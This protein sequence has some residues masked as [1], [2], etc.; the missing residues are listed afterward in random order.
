LPYRFIGHIAKDLERTSEAVTAYE[1]ALERELAAAD[2]HDVRA[3]LAELLVKQNQYARALQVLGDDGRMVPET[4]KVLALRAE[5]LWGQGRLTD[6]RTVLD[7]ALPRHPDAGDLLRLRAKLHL[8][9]GEPQAA[10]SVLERALEIDRH[11]A[12]GR[13]QLAQAYERLG[14]RGD[15]DRQRALLKET[16][17]YLDEITRLTRE[18]MASPWDA[19]VRQRLADVCEKLNKPDLAAMWRR[20]AAACPQKEG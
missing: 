8:E 9:A 6:A 15:A 4:P 11:D 3:N 20:A 18:A 1:K 7:L 16:H 14:R 17:T 13:Y 10:A 5:C 2:A 19:S 12:P